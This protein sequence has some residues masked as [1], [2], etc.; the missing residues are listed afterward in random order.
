MSIRLNCPSCHATFLTSDDQLGR[1]VEC[2]KCG[3][4]QEVPP[5]VL[6]E[7]TAGPAAPTA[8]VPRDDGPADDLGP[9]G[10]G[11]G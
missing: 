5:T 6:D 7:G 4:G 10:A 8:W 9:R 2:P 11:A 3:A 1:R